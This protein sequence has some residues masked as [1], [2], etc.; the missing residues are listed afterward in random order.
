MAPL[1]IEECKNVIKN[2]I[3][4]IEKATL[5]EK[6]PD[7]LISIYELWLDFETFYA[8]ILDRATTW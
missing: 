7:F 3:M 2:C 1:S 8:I 4:A 5:K 6:D